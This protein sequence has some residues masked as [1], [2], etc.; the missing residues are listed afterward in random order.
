MN[1]GDV[2]NASGINAKMI[3]RYEEQGIIGKASRSSAGY[4]QYGENDVHILKFV[5]R[6]RELGFT[7]KDIKE[8]V[9][10]WRN[11]SRQSAKVK[12]IAKKHI[13]ELIVKRD[14]IQAML[15]TLE[16]LVEH[17]HGDARPSCPIIED[18]AS[19]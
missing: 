7:M 8:L 18:L 1:I 4:R 13:E 14:E 5:K 12:T 17:C 10:L 6:S 15:S 19:H 2:A 11:K 9:S 16:H 3:R